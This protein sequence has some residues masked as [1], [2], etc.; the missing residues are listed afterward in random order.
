MPKYKCVNNNCPN[1]DKEIIVQKSVTKFIKGELID[2]GSVCQFCH[3]IM[4][5][6]RPGEGFTTII[7]GSPNI[8]KK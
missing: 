2:T 1:T 8:C 7:G 5:F 3:E 6:I 4:E